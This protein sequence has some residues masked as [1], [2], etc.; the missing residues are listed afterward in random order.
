MTKKERPLFKNLKNLKWVQERPEQVKKRILEYPPYWL[1]KHKQTDYFVR[2]YS[3]S[4]AEDGSCNECVILV[5]VQDNPIPD[6]RFKHPLFEDRTV[7]GTK[8]S[9]LEKYRLLSLEENLLI[10]DFVEIY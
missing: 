10:G 3:Y 9:D 6:L 4:E 7:F 1:Y 2:L 8:F 5:L